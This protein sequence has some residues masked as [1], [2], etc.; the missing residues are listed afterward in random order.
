MLP[1]KKT[2]SLETLQT[3]H[4]DLYEA[5]YE[6]GKK[7]LSVKVLNLSEKNVQLSTELTSVK[8]ELAT[9]KAENVKYTSA[10]KIRES[11]TR[12]GLPT[13]G[14]QLIT[15]GKSVEDALSALILELNTKGP[16]KNELLS[17]FKQT[18]SEPAGQGS[19]DDVNT[20][21]TYEEAKKA[22]QLKDPSLRG[23][24]LVKA[25]HTNYPELMNKV[26]EGEG[27]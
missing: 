6:E 8:A 21:K 16:E 12:L 5:V 4:P 3:D 11:A 13:L 26:R 20:P 10:Q 24:A 27:E 2:L 15:E 14:E 9:V 17:V 23:A 25:V 18:A 1:G 19:S 7:E 22:M